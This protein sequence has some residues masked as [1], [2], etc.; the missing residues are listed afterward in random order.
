MYEKIWGKWIANTGIYVLNIMFFSTAASCS[1][2]N[3]SLLLYTQ[4][5]YSM[6]PIGRKNYFIT[7]G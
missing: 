3:L 1:I 7:G 6:I 2:C 5:N 4:N